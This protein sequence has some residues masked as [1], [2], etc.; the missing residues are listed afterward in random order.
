MSFYRQQEAIAT[1]SCQ[2]VMGSYL[3]FLLLSVFV[4]LLS[5]SP[6][7][8]TPPFGHPDQPYDRLPGTLETSHV[9]WARPLNGGKLDVLFICP[10][11]NSREV[12]ELAQ[13]LDV[14]A[15]VIM[16]AAHTGWA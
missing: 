9:P 14:N 4:G 7:V 15:T 10:Y 6:S 13:R 2:G 16:S 12:V 3:R 5:A 1:Y 11:N 8:G